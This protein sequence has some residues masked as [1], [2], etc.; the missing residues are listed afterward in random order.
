VTGGP[1]LSPAVD[2]LA[3]KICRL[4]RRYKILNM[5]GQRKSD[6]RHF[7]F[8][9]ENS[10]EINRVDTLLLLLVADRSQGSF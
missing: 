6:G 9:P 3:I 4:Q 8:F 2:L 1:S 7:F 10:A 5:H